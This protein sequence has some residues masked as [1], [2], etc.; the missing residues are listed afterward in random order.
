MSSQFEPSAQLL[1]EADYAVLAQQAAMQRAQATLLKKYIGAREELLLGRDE[2]LGELREWE[3]DVD[4]AALYKSLD[5]TSEPPRKTSR[6]A[7]D[8]VCSLSHCAQLKAAADAA[9]A[10]SPERNGMTNVAVG[11]V[12]AVAAAHR[13]EGKCGMLDCRGEVLSRLLIYKTRLQIMEH[14]DVPELYESGSVITRLRGVSGSALGREELNY[15][16]RHVDKANIGSYD[17]SALL[18]LSGRL[19]TELKHATA[20]TNP[21]RLSLGGYARL[22]KGL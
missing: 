7:L 9:M 12:G 17:Y 5:L 4:V 19:S 16:V 1:S 22:R 8:E 6:I 18:Y 2:V 13:R 11:A 14:Y 20:L 21:M 10:G 15:A 3:L